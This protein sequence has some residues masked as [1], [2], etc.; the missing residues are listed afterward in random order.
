MWGKHVTHS[1]MGNSLVTTAST[2]RGCCV[3]TQAQRTGWGYRK[4][5]KRS[6]LAYATVLTTAARPTLGLMDRH[7]WP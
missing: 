4:P 3:P 1:L 5:A 2:L 6:Q 7:I